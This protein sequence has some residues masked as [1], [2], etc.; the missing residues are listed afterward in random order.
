[1]ERVSTSTIALI[2]DSFPRVIPATLG[3]DRVH[4][5]SIAQ[6]LDSADRSLLSSVLV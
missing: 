2:P 1:M 5:K 4:E 3:R 6:Q